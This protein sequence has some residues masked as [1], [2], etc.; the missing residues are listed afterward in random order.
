MKQSEQIQEIYN[1]LDANVNEVEELRIFTIQMVTFLLH[2]SHE[3]G[4]DNND[5]PKTTV[6]LK[7]LLKT[8]EQIMQSVLSRQ[9]RMKSILLHLEELGLKRVEPNSVERIELPTVENLLSG[10]L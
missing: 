10:L 1:L 7:D 3:L 9:E 8:N 6:A 4:I 2:I 5:H